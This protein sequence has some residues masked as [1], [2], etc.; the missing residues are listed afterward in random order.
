MLRKHGVNE[1]RATHEA[2]DLAYQLHRRWVGITFTFPV[3]DEL[4]M[5]RLELHIMEEYVGTNAS[6]LVR[7]YGVTEGRLYSVVR[8]H[9][10]RRIDE[11]QHV[12]YL[13]DGLI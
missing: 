11:N 12:L 4:A 5:A 1:E 3:K 8:K 9:Q 6:H 2:D 10:K 7:R 13:G